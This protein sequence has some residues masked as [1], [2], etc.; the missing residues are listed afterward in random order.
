MNNINR[1]TV[2]LDDDPAVYRY[3][4][5]ATGMNSLPFTSIDT[6][7]KRTPHLS[8]AAVFVDV[9]LN[10]RE[11]GLDIISDLK[12]VW[13][14]APLFVVTSRPDE[15]ILEEALD[16]GADDFLRKPINKSELLARLRVR[17]KEIALRQ[18]QEKV[19]VENF[20]YSIIHQT[21]ENQGNIVKLSKIESDLFFLLLQNR[22]T[23]LDRKTITQQIWGNKNISDNTIDKKISLLRKNLKSINAPFELKSLYGKGIILN[24]RKK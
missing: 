17:T 18:R 22:N 8:P 5:R 14:N 9:N 1:Y 4:A 7:R 21:M 16:L 20:T 19:V 12:K 24:T 2:T 13:P 3:I 11:S 6:L 15:S 10:H 23:M